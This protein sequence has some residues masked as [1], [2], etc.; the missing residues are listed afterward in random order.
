MQWLKSV[1][2]WLNGFK[3]HMC[4]LF[5]RGYCSAFFTHMTIVHILL[6]LTLFK[7]E[8]SLS[9][10]LGFHLDIAR[11]LVGLDFDLG[12]ARTAISKLAPLEE[13]RFVAFA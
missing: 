3:C 2:Q 13:H 7:S 12:C 11:R 4:I 6:S 5:N 1:F 8:R 9:R 10:C